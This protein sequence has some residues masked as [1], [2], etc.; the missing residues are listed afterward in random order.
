MRKPD[1][2]ERAAY[3]EAGHA[4]IAH[5]HAIE[6]H[7]AEYVSQT[8]YGSQ[9]RGKRQRSA[10]DSTAGLFEKTALDICPI[11][12]ISIEHYRDVAGVTEHAYPEF[13]APD[14]QSSE[15]PIWEQEWHASWAVM[16]FMAGMVAEALQYGGSWRDF[17]DDG[18]SDVDQAI[19]WAQHTVGLGPPADTCLE[20]HATRCLGILSNE[21]TH[22]PAVDSVARAL[23]SQGQL[24]CQAFLEAVEQSLYPS[25]ASQEPPRLRPPG[26]GLHQPPWLGS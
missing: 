2:R 22:W 18:A 13:F 21:F 24:D 9:L 5:L 4:M 16:C 14:S 3:H 12:H 26:L 10:G 8:K 11:K 17:L 25:S 7:D 15:L 1:T 6:A 19:H 20:Y 23:L